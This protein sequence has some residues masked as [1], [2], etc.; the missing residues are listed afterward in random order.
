MRIV[1]PWLCPSLPAP[2]LADGALFLL[3]N[4]LFRWFSELHLTTAVGSCLFC[5]QS[6]LG[7][8]VQVLTVVFG[9]NASHF[10]EEV[11]R[12][13]ESCC[14]KRSG[15]SFHSLCLWRPQGWW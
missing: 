11:T 4:K 8:Q 9:T 2:C 12:C 5:F 13:S 6:T 10:G 1:T 15:C 14:K 7:C 3:V